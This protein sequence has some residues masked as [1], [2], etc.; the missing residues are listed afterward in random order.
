MHV[1]SLPRSQIIR[2]P[3]RPVTP[4]ESLGVQLI[5]HV[6]A[7]GRP[8]VPPWLELPGCDA[9]EPGGLGEYVLLMKRC[10]AQ[11]TDDRPSFQEIADAI[12]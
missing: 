6:V 3:H 7:G 5:K 8:T 4:H 2:P 12:R 11:R 1:A 10:W 9:L